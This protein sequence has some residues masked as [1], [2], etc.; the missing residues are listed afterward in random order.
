VST[1]RNLDWLAA[2][3]AQ[4][5]VGEKRDKTQAEKLENM[6]T[7]ALGVVQENG[8]YAGMLFLYSRKED[9]ANEIRGQLLKMLAAEELTP[10]NLAQQDKDQAWSAVSKHLIG[11]VTNDLDTLLLVKDLYEQTL[12]YV[13]YGAKA[14]GSER[15]GHA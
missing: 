7:K 2:S 9:E 15:D 5:I 11:K 3:T 6:A 13:R 8:V 4:T 1:G 10:L 14:A 12:I